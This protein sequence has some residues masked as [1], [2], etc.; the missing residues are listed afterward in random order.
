M[1]SEDRKEKTSQKELLNGELLKLQQ[2]MKL[3][4]K[5]LRRYESS[6]RALRAKYEKLDRELFE[7]NPGIKIIKA[8]KD[9]KMRKNTE[10]DIFDSYEKM[11]TEEQKRALTRLLEIQT[12]MSQ[13]T[14][15]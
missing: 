4:V 2:K 5:M 14:Q 6:F 3:V 1:T 9:T 11:S 12:N 7:E 13:K 8:R 15:A 10:I